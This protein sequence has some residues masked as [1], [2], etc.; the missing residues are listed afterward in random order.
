[1]T[2][3]IQDGGKGRE[4]LIFEVLTTVQPDIILLQ[5]I[6]DPTIAHEWA[7]A[8]EMNLIVAKGNSLRHAAILSRYPILTWHS[9]SSFLSLSRD[10]LMATIEY[11]PQQS[12][13]LFCVHLSAQPFLIFEWL[14]LREIKSVLRQTVQ[15]SS[16][17]CIIAG[18]FNAVSPTDEPIKKSLPLR[19]RMMLLLQGNRFLRTVVSAMPA[20][21]FHDCFRHLNEDAG[22]TLPP[23]NPTIR[24]DYIFANSTL[25]SKLQNCYVMREPS[26]VEHASD[27]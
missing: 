22:F 27:H 23:P 1:M 6:I 3:N 26:A 5:E 21:Q 13:N 11:Q 8:L 19:L 9:A 20:A 14:R 2:Y 10:F 4:A 7:V 12:I 25:I 24:F 16:T 18:D 17:P 15:S